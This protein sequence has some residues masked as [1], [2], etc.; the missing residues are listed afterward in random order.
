MK[1][2][3]IPALVIDLLELI[4]GYVKE[5]YVVEKPHPLVPAISTRSLSGPEEEIVVESRFLL[6][7]LKDREREEAKSSGGY[8]STA[9]FLF[10]VALAEAEESK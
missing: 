4:D 7:K 6:I 5:G 8:A 2:L 10:S 3:E 1:R 9:A